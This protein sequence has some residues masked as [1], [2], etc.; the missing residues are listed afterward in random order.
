MK[1]SM[2]VFLSIAIVAAVVEL[3]SVSRWLANQSNDLAVIAGF[4][5]WLS[6]WAIGSFFMGRLWRTQIE[7]LHKLLKRRNKC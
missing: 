6:T 3:F 7:K 1:T 5:L 4:L 2:S